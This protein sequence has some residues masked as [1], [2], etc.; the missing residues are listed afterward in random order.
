MTWGTCLY[1]RGESTQFCWHITATLQN[2]KLC[3]YTVY[4][5][6]NKISLQKQNTE[7]RRHSFGFLWSFSAW[8]SVLSLTVVQS[9]LFIRCGECFL[10]EWCMLCFYKCVNGLYEIQHNTYNKCKSCCNTDTYPQPQSLISKV[11]LENTFNTWNSWFRMT[12][13]VIVV[14]PPVMSE[15]I[16]F[17][18]NWC[19]WVEFKEEFSGISQETCHFHV[20]YMV[21]N[22]NDLPPSFRKWTVVLRFSIFTH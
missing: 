18:M 16:F 13:T 10:L 19:W 15:I 11:T 8:Y 12:V 5:H 7:K 1:F 22:I 6:D 17:M 21:E 3:A 14:W 2:N 4:L 9:C 20:H